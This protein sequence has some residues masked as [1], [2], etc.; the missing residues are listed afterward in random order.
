[1]RC[2]EQADSDREHGDD[3]DD[4]EG[5]G[6]V[7]PEHAGRIDEEIPRREEREND[8]RREP[9]DPHSLEQPLEA[10]DG[11]DELHRVEDGLEY[12]QREERA[13]HLVQ[14]FEV[15]CVTERRDRV[16][17]AGR[18]KLCESGRLGLERIREKLQSRQ[19][20]P[21][22]GRRRG[23]L[24]PSRPGPAGRQCDSGRR[25]WYPSRSGP[26]SRSTRMA[27]RTMKDASSADAM[28]EA[29][30]RTHRFLGPRSLQ[31]LQ[32]SSAVPAR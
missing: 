4:D 24:R 22:S 21:A 26:V 32:R 11:Q 9:D 3:A 12:E 31:R 25:G 6:E 15:A 17:H 23:R 10:N 29:N 1:M 14:A 5:D 27:V 18:V 19:A 7:D 2:C 30:G 16:G 8:R 28:R 20:D 13:D